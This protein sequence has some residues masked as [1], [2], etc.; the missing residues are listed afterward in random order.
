MRYLFGLLSIVF[1]VGLGCHGRQTKSD[2]SRDK[3]AVSDTMMN[4]IAID[5]VKLSSVENELK[6]TGKVSF[7]E[8]H[9]VRVYPMVSGLASDVRV[10]LG[11]YVKKGQELAVIISSEGAGIQ[12]DLLNATS[13]LGI[14]K[15]NLEASESMYKSGISSEKDFLTAQADFRKAESELDRIKKIITINGNNSTADYSIKAPE[16]GYIVERFINPHMQI[17]PD[18]GNNLFTISDLRHVWIIANVYETDIAKVHLNDEVEVRT[19]AYQ[20]VALKGK[21]DKIAT[22]LDPDNKTMK[23]RI[24]L[25]NE[26]VLLK[27]EM[28]ANV[29]VRYKIKGEMTEIPSQALVFDKSKNFVMLFNDRNDVQ[30]REVQVYSVVGNKTFITS[31]LA[32]GDKVIS[33]CQLLIYN[34]LNE[35]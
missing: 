16:S 32:P 24:I 29:I 34:A 25:G 14:T 9:V 21:I 5:T 27:P 31:G 11:D 18:N 35:S 3:F 6:L 26:N 12:N 7:D 17:R 22:V 20:D 1:L 19:I 15:K 10:S 30:T 23:I 13:N 2:D 8:E 4:M 33:R 28:F